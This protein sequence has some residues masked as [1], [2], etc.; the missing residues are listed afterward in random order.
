VLAQAH[1]H[2]AWRR[3]VHQLVNRIMTIHAKT[4]RAHALSFAA[5][6]YDWLLRHLLGPFFKLRLAYLDARE[7][8]V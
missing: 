8:S 7:L 1:S 2:G 6:S 3:E 4:A 5:R